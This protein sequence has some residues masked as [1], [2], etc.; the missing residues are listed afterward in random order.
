MFKFSNIKTK[1]NST[2][3]NAKGAFIAGVIIGGISC[4]LEYNQITG[5]INW[6]VIGILVVGSTIFINRKKA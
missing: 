6:V 4:F 2:N 1:W 5:L 3:E